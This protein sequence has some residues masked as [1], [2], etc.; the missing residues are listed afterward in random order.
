MGCPEL[1]P[2]PLPQNHNNDDRPD[3]S[4]LT[5][6]LDAAAF[7]ALFLKPHLVSEMSSHH[8]TN[9]ELGSGQG[10]YTLSCVARSGEGPLGSHVVSCVQMEKVLEHWLL[11]WGLGTPPGISLGS[12]G[13][14]W[15]CTG[16]YCSCHR[17][18]G[19]SIGLSDPS[20]TTSFGSVT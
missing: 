7:S 5:F 10:D 12:F 18:L 17:G 6:P 16:T 1:S 8:F 9:G 11:Y 15:S 19:G 3:G 20:P 13:L 4:Y 2:S 14:S